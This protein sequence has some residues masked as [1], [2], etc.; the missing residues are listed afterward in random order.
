MNHHTS[1]R[2]KHRRI[3]FDFGTST[4]TWS[5]T[6]DAASTAT[7]PRCAGLPVR[8][9]SKPL[10]RR[11]ASC[12]RRPT[13]IERCPRLLRTA[14]RTFEPIR[15]DRKNLQRIPGGLAH[16]CS[17][18]R[19]AVMRLNKLIVDDLPG[20]RF[21]HGWMLAVPK[22]VRIQTPIF[23][24]FDPLPQ[25]ESHSAKSYENPPR[26]NVCRKTDEFSGPVIAALIGRFSACPE[27]GLRF[28]A[29]RT[30]T[31]PSRTFPRP[32][33][34]GNLRFGRLSRC[35]GCDDPAL[36]KRCPECDNTSVGDL[37]VA[38]VEFF[39]V[40]ELRQVLGSLIGNIAFAQR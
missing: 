24:V 32:E 10:K 13:P 20:D 35:C 28:R 18:L 6:N 21:D 1:L 19:G 38:Q 23:S 27:K 9:P 33:S 26:G 37:H 40:I 5:L 31:L 25:S 11:R 7:N 2:R 29:A 14:R 34:G 4:S 30:R 8:T 36:R 12:L 16:A 15:A 17:D 39:K 3:R 22:M